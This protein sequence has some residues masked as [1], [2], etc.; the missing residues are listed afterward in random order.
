MHLQQLP[1]TSTDQ[2]GEKAWL[3][4]WPGP[5]TEILPFQLA[6]LQQKQTMEQHQIYVIFLFLLW[7]SNLIAFS[8]EA[9]QCEQQ[10]RQ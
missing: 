5:K 2:E 4:D 9:A 7:C 8:Q 3:F 10:A 6:C 1:E